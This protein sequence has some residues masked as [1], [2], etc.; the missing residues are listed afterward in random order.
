M[1]IV[2]LRSTFNTIKWTN[3]TPFSF[4]SKL[5]IHAW[6]IERFVILTKPYF[7]HTWRKQQI[8]LLIDEYKWTWFC[9]LGHLFKVTKK[10]LWQKLSKCLK[11]MGWK[12]LNFTFFHS[13]SHVNNSCALEPLLRLIGITV[14]ISVLQCLFPKS[15]LEIVAISTTLWI[16]SKYENLIIPI[17]SNSWSNSEFYLLLFF[18]QF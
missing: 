17:L 13:A 7:T 8:L 15:P 14:D 12:C 11:Q 3:S 16:H 5:I 6:L 10:S 1:L 4:F 9:L 2:D 18:H